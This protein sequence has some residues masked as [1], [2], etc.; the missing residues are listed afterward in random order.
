MNLAL[1][2]DI[3]ANDY[4][5]QS[6]LTDVRDYSLSNPLD[7]IV[8]FGDLLTYG[9]RV[10]ETLA[11]VNS[12][13]YIAK[14]KFLLGNHDNAYLQF[15]RGKLPDDFDKL[16]DKSKESFAYTQR[17]LE[18]LDLELRINFQHYFVEGK[19]YLAHATHKRI[20]Y[21]SIKWPYINTL[22]EHRAE[23]RLLSERGFT[24]GIYAHTHRECV[25]NPQEDSLLD[26]KFIAGKQYIVP[27]DS[28]RAFV[29]NIGGPG[30]PRVGAG[31]NSGYISWTLVRVNEDESIKVVNRPCFYD[32]FMQL[33]ALESSGLSS[34]TSAWLGSFFG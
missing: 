24:C 26:H 27:K 8:F 23:S 29:F 25:Y 16:P 3:H 12:A 30:Q 32:K 7:S 15:S 18:A 11:L 9:V 20:D 17:L 6:I 13:R 33:R 22:N 19:C 2:G 14:T 21:D 4:A 1:I 34:D 31:K 28:G 5:L 10:Q